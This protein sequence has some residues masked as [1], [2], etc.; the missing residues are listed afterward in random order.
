MSKNS[1]KGT[2]N[3]SHDDNDEEGE[4]SK[5]F[6]EV[7]KSTKEIIDK[8]KK[9]LTAEEEKKGK[10]DDNYEKEKITISTIIENA[11]D[12]YNSYHSL[13]PEIFA[14]LEKYEPDY[15][16]KMKEIEEAIRLLDQKKNI[17]KSDDMDLWIKAREEMKMMLIGKTTFN[18][19]IAA[20]EEP[21]DSLHKPHK[22]NVALDLILW[23]TGK[24]IKTLSLEEILRTIQKIWV[25]ANYFHM[26]DIKKE[27]EDQYHLILKHRQNKRYSNYW[28]GYFTELLQAEDIPIKCVVEGE[29]F[30]E[31]LSLTV[32]KLHDKSVK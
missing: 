6:A 15:G 2:N 19:L 22:K 4:T 25:V 31:T 9:E 1:S 26:I 12:V 16:S 8:I 11:I 29:A 3:E 17:A 10:L 20:A 30:D 5:L 14:I 23:Y 32:K 27:S 21:K 28:L 24:P 18:Q 13:P 7:K